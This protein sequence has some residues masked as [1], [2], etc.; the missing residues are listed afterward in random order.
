M[1]NAAGNT[2][3]TLRLPLRVFIE[4]VG[5]TAIW[6]NLK[7]QQL[8]DETIRVFFLPMHGDHETP[9]TFSSMV[10]VRVDAAEP[11]NHHEM[12]SYKAHCDSTPSVNT[13]L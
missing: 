5:R 6:R 8:Q 12:Y 4:S 9:G 11:K 1:P 3:V 13:L 10:G 2:A 7:L